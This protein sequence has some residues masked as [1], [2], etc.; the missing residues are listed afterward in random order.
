MIN[1]NIFH[2]RKGSYRQYDNDVNGFAAT[3]KRKLGFKDGEWAQTTEPCH[4]L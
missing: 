3:V 4:K 2:K 1:L